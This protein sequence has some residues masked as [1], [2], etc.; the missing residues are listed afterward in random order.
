MKTHHWLIILGLWRVI[1]RVYSL[2]LISLNF[3]PKIYIFHILCLNRPTL[4]YPSHY[5]QTKHILF[6]Y[7]IRAKTLYSIRQTKHNFLYYIR[8]FCSNIIQK[9]SHFYQ[10]YETYFFSNIIRKICSVCL[11]EMRYFLYYIREKFPNIIQKISYLD[12]KSVV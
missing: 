10:T 6:A 3:L 11:I 5:V 1:Y 2:G 12:R 8:D 7:Y 9:I 4:L